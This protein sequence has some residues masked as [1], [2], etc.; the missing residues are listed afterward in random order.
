MPLAILAEVAAPAA[1]VTL[2]GMMG[3]AP[4]TLILGDNIF[5][6]HDLAPQ[7][8]RACAR[9]NGATV[10]AYP[11]TDP[12]RYGVAEFDAAGRV[13]SLE[14]KPKTPKSR[15]AVT[16]VYFY[17]NRAVALAKSLK[18]S[19]RGELEI[20][21]L[22][23]LYLAE[24][25]LQVELMGR[26][27]AWLDTGTHESLLE[28]STFIATLEKRQGLKI[29]CPEEIAYHKGYITAAELE[30]IAHG[31]MKNNYGQYLLGLLR[32]KVF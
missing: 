11:V 10:F 26:G 16:G 23:R 5:Y 24:G 29:A 32:D 4:A 30:A 1:L 6:G 2:T 25:A 14:E 13:I 22:N 15:Y 12:Q 7:L 17:D 28:A 27:M 18:P 3:D 19:S 8:E 21:D 9:T 20:T 31:M